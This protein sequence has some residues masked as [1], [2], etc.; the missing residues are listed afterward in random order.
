MKE[1]RRIGNITYTLSRNKGQKNL[2]LHLGHNGEILVSSPYIVRIKE[3][4]SFVVSSIPWIEK[5]RS[6]IIVSSFSSGTKIPYMGG[7]LTIEIEF[8]K[9]AY[10]QID[11]E[12]LYIFTPKQDIELVKKQIKKMYCD[13]ILEIVKERVPYW[14][15]KVGV[16]VPQ[17]GVNRAKTKWGV[18]YPLEKRLYLSYMCAILP[19]DLIDMTVLHET[20]HLVYHGHGKAFWNLMEKN[21]PDLKERKTRL[22]EIAKTGCNQTIV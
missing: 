19:Y 22:A 9:K 2:R 20:C 8:G 15:E 1:V 13:T 11:N 3:V 12:K 21:M 7:Y 6:Q 5:H 14:A 18:C 16:S 17:I 4:E 10:Y